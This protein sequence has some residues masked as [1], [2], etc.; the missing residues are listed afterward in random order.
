MDQH[1][2][3]S[4]PVVCGGELRIQAPIKIVEVNRLTG[5][6]LVEH[7]GNRA[8]LKAG[9]TLTLNLTAKIYDERAT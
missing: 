2:L 9:G 5:E 4:S 8:R 7:D 1:C 3:S 6:V